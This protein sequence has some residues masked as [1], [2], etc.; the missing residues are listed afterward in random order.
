[1]IAVLLI[2]GL[3]AAGLGF[4]AGTMSTQTEV[5]AAQAELKTAKDN[6]ETARNT[7]DETEKTISMLKDEKR[8]A[9]LNTK[10]P[11]ATLRVNLNA[12]LKEHVDLGLVALRSAYDGD[13]DTD[14]AVG[15]LDQ[16]S[17]ELAAAVGSVYGDKAETQFLA[18]WRDHIG[19]FV[20]YTVGLKTNNQTKMARANENLKGYA[21]SAGTFFHSANP[22]IP[23]QAVV[24]LAER[25]KELVIAS[26]EAYDAGN[27]KKA[28]KKERQANKQ[29]S[30]LA[31]ALA[32]GIVKQYPDRFVTE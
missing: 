7:V 21:E 8:S 14:A 17:Q 13:A 19:Y 3:V 30:K 2:G 29:I 24:D 5:N 6:L 23:K 11:A 31:D 4:G 28:Y 25:H 15:Q 16:N 22:N 18:L 10:S 12:L 9:M 32:T 27:Y 20:D 26:M 1:M